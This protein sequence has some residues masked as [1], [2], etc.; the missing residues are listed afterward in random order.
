MKHIDELTG[1]VLRSGDPGWD[2]ARHGF[3]AR[4]D[5]DANEPISVVFAETTQDL[6]LIHI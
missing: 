2:D 3:G 5:Y 4:F 6:S 1:R